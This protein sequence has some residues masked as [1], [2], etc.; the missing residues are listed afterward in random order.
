MFDQQEFILFLKKTGFVDKLIQ[1]SIVDKTERMWQNISI[2]Q[3][4]SAASIFNFLSYLQGFGDMIKAPKWK[5]Y[6]LPES[7]HIYGIL[8]DNVFYM[9]YRNNT[10]KTKQLS[11]FYK[12][13]ECFLT[14]QKHFEISKHRVS[15][16]TKTY[17]EKIENID[18]S[19]SPRNT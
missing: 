19:K 7:T 16:R 10:D 14:N 15:Q 5:T 13:F 8:V 4:C 6:T 18:K 9:S 1:N 11:R 17:C 3:K 12:D 2:N